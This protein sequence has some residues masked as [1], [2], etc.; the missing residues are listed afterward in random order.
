M[1]TENTLPGRQLEQHADIYTGSYLAQGCLKQALLMQDQHNIIHI[2]QYLTQQVTCKCYSI[3]LSKPEF[4]FWQNM[5]QCVTKD[6][7]F[8]MG[9]FQLLESEGLVFLFQRE[10]KIEGDRK[11]STATASH[12]VNYYPINSIIHYFS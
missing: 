11:S 3:W 5:S 12:A 2:E 1:D 4:G 9:Y 10:M 7:I 8:H 6:G